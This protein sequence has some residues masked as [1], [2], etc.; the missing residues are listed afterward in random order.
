MRR[1]LIAV[2]ALLALAV[3]A[4]PAP[5][6]STGGARG[7]V[8]DQEGQ[9]ID[10][11]SVLLEYLEGVTRKYEV[12]TNEKGEYIQVGLSP[13]AGA[14]YYITPNLSLSTET[15]FKAYYHQSYYTSSYEGGEDNSSF[16]NGFRMGFS[17]LGILSLN[18]HF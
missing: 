4:P 10:G 16:S 11:A 17:P 15:Q 7:K 13:L 9:P 6:Q 1:A 5:A 14:R 12:R 2:G 8:V 3:L 18:I